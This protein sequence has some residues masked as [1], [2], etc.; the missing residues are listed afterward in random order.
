MKYTHLVLLFLLPFGGLFAQS[1]D[2][3]EQDQDTI[4]TMLNEQQ[5]LDLNSG[6]AV[7]EESTVMEMLDLVGNISMTKDVYLDIDTA[8]WNK[9]HFSRGEVPYY[10]DSVYMQ[11]IQ[12]LAYETTIPLTFNT[13]VKSFI[14]LYANRRRQ[15][16]SRMLGLSY[17]YFPMFEEYLSRYNLPL[18]LKY[19][20][21]VES[22]LN[23][24][25]G[26]KA[27]AKGLWQFMRG[28]GAEYGLRVTSLVDERY[29][30]MKETEAACQYLQ[31]LYARYEDWFLVLAAYNSGPGTVNKAI[32]RAGGVK[33]YW[34]IWP[35]LPKE[36]RGYVPAFIAVVYVMN[37]AAEHNLYPVNPGLLL[38]GTDTVM[39]HDRV[40]FDQ[41]N[42]CIGAP[43][44]D[45]VF[46]N[47]QYTKRV[48][49]GTKEYPYAL[50]MPTK[51]VL[52]FT[53]LEDSIYSY[54]SKA[55]KAREV[56]EEKVEE[57]SDSFVHVVKKGESLGSIA[58]K[59]HVTVAK[60]KSWNRLKRET[61]HIGQKLTIYRSGAPMAQVGKTNNNSKASSNKQASPSVR[62]HTVRKGE[63]LSSIARKYGCTVNDIKKWNGMKSNTVKIGQKLKIKK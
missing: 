6:K 57:V 62:T 45:L 27:G 36:T 58:R 54:V 8:V 52:R 34:A 39:V 29:D 56:I 1:Y 30:P 53:Q 24:T 25:A 10:D 48:I 35:Y 31:S 18:E 42:E 12:T 13:H 22:A 5:I 51:Y 44:N 23:P 17:V 33:N 9:Y 49:P 50:R 60:I 14:D 26:S 28:T 43:M 32:L 41:I 63:T 3:E 19:L 21:M 7:V 20:A 37:Y 40:G 2:P 38:H 55:E 47:P 11:R 15:Q 46:F 4:E 61:I 16:T 59:Y